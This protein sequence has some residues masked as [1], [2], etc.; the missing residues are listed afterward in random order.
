LASQK[1]ALHQLI[2]V[3]ADIFVHDKQGETPLALA[4]KYD[5]AKVVQVLVKAG[6]KISDAMLE[7]VSPE[8]RRSLVED[9]VSSP[10]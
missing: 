9:E 4:I 1:I 10:L 3:G 7:L 6:A 5:N 8:L 2:A